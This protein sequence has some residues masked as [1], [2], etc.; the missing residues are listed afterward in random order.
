[1]SYDRKIKI[2]YRIKDFKQIT[3]NYICFFLDYVPGMN[4]TICS[5]KTEKGDRIET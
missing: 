4:I 5:F 3:V 1:M 2:A